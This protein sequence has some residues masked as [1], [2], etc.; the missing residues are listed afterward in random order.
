MSVVPGRRLSQYG[1]SELSA[2]IAAAGA[3]TADQK[4][5]R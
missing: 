1:A 4:P 3:G 2:K 5:G